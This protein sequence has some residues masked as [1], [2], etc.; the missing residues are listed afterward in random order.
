VRSQRDRYLRASPENASSCATLSASAMA[1][2]GASPGYF[3]DGHD[4]GASAGQEA[5]Q[6]F[7][8]CTSLRKIVVP[9]IVTLLHATKPMRLDPSAHVAR[10]A[11]ISQTRFHGSS[12][13]S[14]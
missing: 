2:C 4:F 13:V 11:C 12:E 7:Q 8:R 10:Y 1:V 9:V 14:R 6:N 5:M 3:G